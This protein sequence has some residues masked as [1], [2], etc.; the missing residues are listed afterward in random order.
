MGGEG[1]QLGEQGKGSCVRGKGIHP[2]SPR[3]AQATEHKDDE[4][5]WRAFLQLQAPLGFRDLHEGSV[6]ATWIGKGLVLF[7]P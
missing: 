7:F 2:H 1:A 4:D 3:P 5:R 6:W